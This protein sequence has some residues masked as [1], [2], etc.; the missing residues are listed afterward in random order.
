MTTPIEEKILDILSGLCSV[1]RSELRPEVH[2][3][4]DLGLDSVIT[5]DLLITLEEEL[6]RDVSEVEAARLVT[7]GDVMGFVRRHGA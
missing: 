3:V 2:L 1:A 5:L 6:G 7:V 4:R